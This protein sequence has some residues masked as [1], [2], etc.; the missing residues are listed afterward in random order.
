MLLC[1][2]GTHDRALHAQHEWY[3][4]KLGEL[5]SP[6]NV[7]LNGSQQQHGVWSGIQVRL[8]ALVERRPLHAHEAYLK[9]ILGWLC[10]CMPLHRMASCCRRPLLLRRA[11][12]QWRALMHPSSAQ[13]LPK[14]PQRPSQCPSPPSVSSSVSQLQYCAAPVLSCTCLLP[15]CLPSLLA[16]ACQQRH[17]RDSACL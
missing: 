9:Q 1:E 10:S 12:S 15:A 17:S 8:A 13:S 11:C 7:V 16:C 3:M 2:R 6:M 5:V 14:F 4:D